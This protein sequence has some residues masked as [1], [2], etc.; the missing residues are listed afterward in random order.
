MLEREAADYIA[1]VK[2]HKVVG[3]GALELEREATE[4]NAPRQEHEVAGQGSSMRDDDYGED[5][6]GQADGEDDEVVTTQITNFRYFYFDD[7]FYFLL[8]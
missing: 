8:D 4:H 2:E 1:P 5:Y 7:E 6:D 3:H